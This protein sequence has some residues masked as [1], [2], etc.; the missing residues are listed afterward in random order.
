M[1]R[2]TSRFLLFVALAVVAAGCGKADDSSVN[3]PTTPAPTTV[4]DSFAG[5]LTLNGAATYPFTVTT[6]GGISAQLTELKP[7]DSGPVGLSLGTWN[8]SIC[9]VG[10]GMFNDKS[11]QGSVLVGQ[12]QAAGNFCVRIYDAA[13]T[14]ANP[15]T[16]VIEVSHL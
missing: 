12:A 15:E 6:A 2:F 7:G 3:T 8:N 5:I 1:H 11:I 4:T 16:Y 14:V 9:T 10:Q 13:G